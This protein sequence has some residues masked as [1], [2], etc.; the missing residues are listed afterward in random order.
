M[1]KFTS[2]PLSDKIAE[3]LVNNG[4]EI[5]QKNS[6]KSF[7]EYITVVVRDNSGNVDYRIKIRVSDH[8]LPMGSCANIDIRT[9]QSVESAIESLRNGRFEFS[10]IKS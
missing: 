6:N 1:T 3:I 4:F 7:S 10:N 2:L 8:N 5:E 9:T